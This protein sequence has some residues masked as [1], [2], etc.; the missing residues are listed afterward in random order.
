[1]DS[2]RSLIWAFLFVALLVGFTASRA[3]AQSVGGA[4]STAGTVSLLGSSSPG[5]LLVC[6]GSTWVLAEAFTSGGLVGIGTTVP[7]QPLEVNGNAKID[8]TL[9]FASN[10]S[11]IS[12]DSNITYIGA[13]GGATALEVRGDTGLIIGNTSNGGSKTLQIFPQVA[14]NTNWGGNPFLIKPGSSTGNGAAPYIA[15]YSGGTGTS[16]TQVNS[17]FESMR[18]DGNGNVGISTTSPGAKLDVGLAGTTLGTMRLEGSTSGYVQIQSAAAAGSWTMTLPPNGGSAN[19][20]LQTDGSGNTTWVAAPSSSSG[21]TLGTS[22]GATNP[23]RSGQVGTG[24]Y[25][26]TSNEVE[27]AVNGVNADTWSSTGENVTGNITTLGNVQANTF[28]GAAVVG[29]GAYGLAIYDNQNLGATD[30]GRVQIGDAQ[31][32][33]FTSGF[34][35]S[36][37]FSD[38]IA[39]SSGS[40]SF[41]GLDVANTINQTGTA[42]GVTAGIYINPTVTSAHDYRPFEIP[43]LTINLLGNPVVS[44]VHAGAYLVAPTITATSASQTVTTASTL[45]I[46]GAPSAGTHVAITN[47][48]ALYV[49]AGNADFG[50]NVGIG[51]TSPQ[52]T[53]DVNGYARLSLNSSQPAA[54]SSSNPG[55]IALNHLAQ[56]CVCNGA[57]WQF[58]STGA[59]CS[60]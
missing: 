16:G 27:V 23:Q 3:D 47:P 31:S 19:Y 33:T 29:I 42:T 50:G 36:L 35:A 46:A 57:A 48:L 51:T 45:D 17:L 44:N 1:M 38:G 34:D 11:T 28:I 7:N 2:R 26:D 60:W 9:Y 58:D 4:C 39:S 21:I 10:D 59:V 8:G 13:G 40:G 18:L 53:L 15:F 14:G 55:A 32:Y 25:S 30:S 12:G 43:A 22:A 54:C 20:I 6:N 56:I 37:L 5:E 52:A 49:E 24:F 41:Y